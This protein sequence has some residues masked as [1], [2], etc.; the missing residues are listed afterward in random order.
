MEIA[1]IAKVL[2]QGQKVSAVKALQRSHLEPN[3]GDLT[4][5]SLIAAGI[6]STNQAQ[7]LSA[8]GVGLD[9]TVLQLCRNASAHLNNDMLSQIDAIKVRY[10]ETKYVHPSDF[11]FWVDPATKDFLWKTWVAE[12]DVIS[13]FAIV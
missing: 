8:L 7:L 2:S 11:I 13:E 9:I 1:Y 3:W 4:K 5:A 12:M 6:N 10:S